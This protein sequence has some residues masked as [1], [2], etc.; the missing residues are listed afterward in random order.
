VYWIQEPSC[1]GCR[2]VRALSNL[3]GVPYK[4]SAGARRFEYDVSEPYGI[5][6]V[7]LR[8]PRGIVPISVHAVPQNAPLLTGADILGAQQR[9][10]RD[11]TDELGSTAG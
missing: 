3:T 1:I 8:T 9:Y 7:P 11:V 10:V 6:T 4:L 2:Q 5:F